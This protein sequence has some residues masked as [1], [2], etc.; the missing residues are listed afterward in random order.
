MDLTRVPRSEEIRRRAESSI[1]KW[2]ELLPIQDA[3]A[4][5]SL[6]EGYTPLI[7]A[8]HLGQGSGSGACS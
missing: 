4:I 3:P 6:G 8:S 1:W 2:W 5:T 7:E